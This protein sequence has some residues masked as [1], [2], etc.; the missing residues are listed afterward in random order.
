MFLVHPCAE[1]P[2]YVMTDL[3]VNYISEEIVVCNEF[4]NITEKALSC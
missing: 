4:Y 2:V 3:D 1:V